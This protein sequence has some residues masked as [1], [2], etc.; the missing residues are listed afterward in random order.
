M[1]SLA[2]LQFR[3]RAFGDDR[4]G[5]EVVFGVHG[6]LGDM[7]GIARFDP[8]ALPDTALHAVPVLLSGKRLPEAAARAI[9]GDARID[10][11][12]EGCPAG[13]RFRDVRVDRR[14]AVVVDRDHRLVDAHDRLVKHAFEDDNDPTT[15]PAGRNAH[16]TPIAPGA[17]RIAEGR[18]LRLPD[19]R[20]SDGL[21]L[22]EAGGRRPS[23]SKSQSPSR[24]RDGRR[25]AGVR[26]TLLAAMVQLRID[27]AG[28][29]FGSLCGSVPK[30]SANLIHCSTAPNREP[31]T[32]H[33]AQLSGD[34]SRRASGRSAW[35]GLARARAHPPSPASKRRR[36]RQRHRRD[37]RS[38]AVDRLVQSPGFG[39]GGPDPH[40]D[41]EGEEGA[42]ESLFRGLRRSAR[43]LPRRFRTRPGERNRSR[44]A[45]R[46]VHE[47]RSERALRALLRRKGSSASSTCRRPSS[48]PTG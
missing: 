21:A 37:A 23:N 39:A 25:K 47:L 16:R 48:T 45:D 3:E 20:R 44:H 17:L 18:K 24:L 4:P 2:G 32:R 12:L 11:E 15:G 6:K 31:Q 14:P 10:A 8:R 1:R 13:Q 22:G 19:A 28:R 7:Q 5:G 33:V 40:R 43:P 9:V 46:L 34:R 29:G 36:Q 38:S 35:P 30:I 42:S 41:A 26:I 27:L